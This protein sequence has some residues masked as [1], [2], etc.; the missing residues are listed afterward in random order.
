[1]NTKK[2]VFW[3]LGWGHKGFYFPPPPYPLFP[4][5]PSC[6][7]NPLHRWTA[8]STEETPVCEQED[9][10]W[11]RSDLVKVTG[12]SCYCHQPRLPLSSIFFFISACTGRNTSRSTLT[13]KVLIQSRFSFKS[14]ETELSLNTL[15]VIFQLS[16][17]CF[18]DFAWT[19]DL[20]G[21]TVEWLL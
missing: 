2:N 6:F 7:S 8:M 17:A 21:G 10:V 9:I 19:I 14:S 15:T 4:R 16:S 20:W 13:L 3:G 18:R 1:M 11:W 12:I 5:Y